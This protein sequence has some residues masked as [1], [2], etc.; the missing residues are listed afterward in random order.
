G[1]VASSACKFRAG[2]G[3]KKSSPQSPQPQTGD[4]STINTFSRCGDSQI[5]HGCRLS[6]TG[7]L[8]RFVAATGPMC[9]DTKGSDCRLGKRLLLQIQFKPGFHRVVTEHLNRFEGV[10]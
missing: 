4:F 8:T 10:F 3:V 2:S 6:P 9:G 1:L 5:G 7:C